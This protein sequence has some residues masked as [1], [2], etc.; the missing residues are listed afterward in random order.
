MTH[1]PLCKDFAIGDTDDSIRLVSNPRIMSNDYDCFPFLGVEIVENL[2]HV[3][4]CQAIERSCGLISKN[5]GRICDH[6]SGNGDT[7]FLT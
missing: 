5:D 4:R 2:H 7:G 6:S 1:S 3:F